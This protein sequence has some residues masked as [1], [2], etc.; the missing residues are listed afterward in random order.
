M[1]EQKSETMMANVYQGTGKPSKWMRV[2]KAKIEQDTDVLIRVHKTTICGT[3]LHILGGNVPQTKPGII[4]G[5]EGIGMIVEAGSAVK[6]YNV[7]DRILIS[8]ITACGHCKH[9]KKEPSEHAHC[10]DGGWQFGTLINGMQAEY[11][12]V[13][14]ADFTAYYLPEEVKL[15][16][17]QE[18]AYVMASDVLPTSYEIGLRGGR[19]P[20]SKENSVAVIGAGPLGLAC[21]LCAAEEM[22][23][24][25]KVFAVDLAPAR[26][27]RAKEL[28]ATHLI[29]NSKGDCVEQIMAATNGKGVDFVVECI[30]L[31]IGW[32]ICQDLVAI[33][34]EISILGVHGKPG[35]FALD[36]LWDRNVSIHTGMVHG[37][38]IPSFL[39][40]IRTGAMAAEKLISHPFSLKDVEEAYGFFKGAARTGSL[41]VLITNDVTKDDL[42]PR[43]KEEADVE[44]EA[45][46][47]TAAVEAQ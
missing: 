31:P 44:A 19:Y 29:N 32:S 5:H 12:R 41:K 3:D 16:S 47:Q 6:K 46:T 39:E 43:Q 30:G 25:A 1:E 35:V 2:E 28:G 45:E 9:C 10:V 37:Y 8:C 15:G 22:E 14:H 36:K 21:I 20:K 13:P 26:L 38:T 18:D 42:I 33:G 34:G 40:K 11:C 4:L 17:P 27:E 7:G 23:V 24:G